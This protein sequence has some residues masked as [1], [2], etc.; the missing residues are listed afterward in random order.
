MNVTKSDLLD[1]K[2]RDTTE[3]CESCG[4][5]T[6][7]VL[8]GSGAGICS[9]CAFRRAMDFLD[10]DLV[11][12]FFHTYNGDVLKCQ[13]QIL[14]RVGNGLY[15]VQTFEWLM[16]TEYEQ[17]IESLANMT[18]WKFYNCP[19]DMQLAYARY[20]SQQERQKVR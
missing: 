12:K 8:L 14:S 5:A 1:W 15:L 7:N 9:G 19:E 2:I 13:G 20:V 4:M 18:S 17:H 6:G 11:G 3:F 16:G 10:S